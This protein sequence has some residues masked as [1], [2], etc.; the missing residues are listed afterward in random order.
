VKRNFCSLIAFSG[1]DGAGKSTQINL[2]IE[3]L[4]QRGHEPIYLWTRGGYT[5]ILEFFK[6]LLRRLP[7]RTVPPLGNN[8]QRTRAFRRGWVRRL[9]LTLAL[10]DLIWLIL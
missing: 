2:L 5:P 10:L 7:G 1:L 3:R 8:P 6:T 9:W 4:R